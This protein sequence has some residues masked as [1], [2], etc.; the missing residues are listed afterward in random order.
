MK[1]IMNKA[2]F[3]DKDGTLVPDV[4]YNVN[5]KLVSI[6]KNSLEGLQLIKD[7][8][9]KLIVISNQSGIARG[10]FDIEK[11]RG[12]EDKI[13]QL[14]RVHNL[15]VDGFYYCPH[16]TNDDC[17]CRKPN[18]GLILKAAQDFNIDLAQSWMIGDILNDVEAGNRAGCK[19][20][21]ID[22]GNETEWILNENREPFFKASSINEAAEL[23]QRSLKEATPEATLLNE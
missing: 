14:L 8:G 19:T 22:N 1:E 10:Y 18:P 20:I 7:S 4:P 2:I 16:D 17:D 5:P 13:Q 3:L 15:K 6:E 11:L 9:F 21:L 12:V 23:I